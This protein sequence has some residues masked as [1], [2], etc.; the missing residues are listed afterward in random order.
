[1]DAEQL[2]LEGFFGEVFELTSDE[3]FKDELRA[4]ITTKFA[5]VRSRRDQT[6]VG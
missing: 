1:L 3:S 6:E 4:K 5:K 2:I